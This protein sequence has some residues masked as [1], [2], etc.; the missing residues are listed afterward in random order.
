MT[1]SLPSIESFG[2]DNPALDGLPALCPVPV[3][4]PEPP[5]RLSVAQ[6]VYDAGMLAL[7]AVK[8]L[9]DAL[10][11]C[12]A[13]IVDRVMG[14]A[15]VEEG[16]VALDRWQ[17]GIA[18]GSAITNMALVLRIPEVTASSLAYHA[19]DLREHFPDTMAALGAGELSWRHA[20]IVAD[21]IGTLRMNPDTTD[22]DVVVF[23]GKLLLLAKG[24]T[25]GCFASKA[26]RARESM[27]PG[28]IIT[29]TK[30]AF[31]ERRM[32]N[33]P[34]K[35]NMSWM[36]FH[37]PT[38]TANAIMTRCTRIARAM[39]ADA[40]QCQQAADHAG[41]GEDCREHRTLAQLRVDIAA[42]QLLG[43][44]L[45]AGAPVK[46]SAGATGQP[47]PGAAKS[48]S[49][50]T[51]NTAGGSARSRAGQGGGSWE[52]RHSVEQFSTSGVRLVDEE[53]IWT[54]TGPQQSESH[55]SEHSTVDGT[56]S[57]TI[58]PDTSAS[59]NA[60]AADAEVEP[61]VGVVLG[62]GSGFIDGVVDGIVEHPVQ[63]YLDQLQALAQGLNVQGPPLPAATIL[64]KV[65]FLGLLNLTDEPAELV[66]V[67]GGPVPEDIAR[68]LLAGSSTFLRVL[69]D[70]VS[71]ELMP[72]NPDRYTLRQV[73]KDL[74]RAMA[75]SCYFPN[76]TNP[77]VDTDIDHLHAFEHGGKSTA[78]NLRPACRKHH[79][80]RHFK[81]DKDRHGNYRRYKEPH[82]NGI[83]L[84]GWTP[85]PL[86]DGR[87]AWIT[88]TGAIE[89]PQYEEP[90]RTMYPKWLKKRITKSLTPE[91]PDKPKEPGQ[92]NND[93]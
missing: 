45:P 11:A 15:K 57:G 72:V 85:K 56:L 14:A 58:L 1:L 23:E 78:A 93:S 26:R 33:E 19:M 60:D 76:C 16:T 48:S 44:D 53:P 43:Q 20:C 80:L 91:P 30:Q 88:P 62:D 49:T 41:S 81:D 67:D 2:S 75:E 87:I 63:E 64:L 51:T 32:V 70:P 27:F 37:L 31:A 54:H 83:K 47:S 34:G 50:S 22:D 73:E 61:L 21:E 39:K 77:V 42:I 25:A 17:R 7:G 82:R 46:T 59:A 68:K 92:P 65:P 36:S 86:P 5:T 66:G 52:E 4:V 55:A 3:P 28:T 90:Q 9:E 10:A 79:A 8:V 12:K 84:R 18:Q 74:L 35:D 40:Q 71:G 38:V 69:T 13:G 29:R 89:P 6:G 24:T